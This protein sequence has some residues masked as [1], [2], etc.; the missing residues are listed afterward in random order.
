MLFFID[1]RALIIF[2]FDVPQWRQNKRHESQLFE[3]KSHLAATLTSYS[4]GFK[5]PFA[6]RWICGYTI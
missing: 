5:K 4:D 3:M 2:S 6:R 1:K